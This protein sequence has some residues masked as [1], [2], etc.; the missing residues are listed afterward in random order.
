M[1]KLKQEIKRCAYWMCGKNPKIKRFKDGYQIRC[2][3]CGHNFIELE[4]T[5]AEAIEKWNKRMS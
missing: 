4:K 2:Y 1:K 3:G 5:K